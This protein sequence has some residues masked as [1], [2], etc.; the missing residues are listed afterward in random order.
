MNSLLKGIATGG[1]LIGLTGIAHANLIINGCCEET[2]LTLVDWSVV[3]AVDGEVTVSTLGIETQNK[4][5]G[6]AY[7]GMQLAELDNH[8]DSAMAH[9]VGNFLDSVSF[10]VAAPIPEP[11]SLLLF[12]TGMVGLTSWI[13]RRRA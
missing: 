10:T 7:D 2:A 12:G 5:T 1:L 3:N 13:R 4:A 6:P 11:A 9:S 8:A